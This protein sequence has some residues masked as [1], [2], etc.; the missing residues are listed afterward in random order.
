MSRPRTVQQFDLDS[1]SSSG[2]RSRLPTTERSRKSSR[3][4]VTAAAA[5]DPAQVLAH[6]KS[7]LARQQLIEAQRKEAQLEQKRERQEQE[8]KIRQAEFEDR[9]SAALKSEEDEIRRQRKL[10]AEVLDNQNIY[11][12]IEQIFSQEKILIRKFIP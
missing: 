1:R 6:R 4:Q 10:K 7:E 11:N 8:K 5:A 2:Q 9:M 3:T 12:A